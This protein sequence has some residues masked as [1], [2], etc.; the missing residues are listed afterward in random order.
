MDRP[1]R[2]LLEFGPFRLDPDER[3]LL[4]GGER[5]PLP[6]KSL[7]ILL[8]LAQHGGHLFE[9]DELLKAVWPE[10]V[11]EEA[12]IAVHVAALRRALGD[13]QNGRHY[14]ETERGHGYRFTAK[15]RKVPAGHVEP[16]EGRRAGRRGA[17]TV[18]PPHA[19]RMA[20]HPA[21][22][23]ED[24]AESHPS[25][26]T[27]EPVGGA[28]PLDS[29]FYIERPAD[30]EFTSAVLR[31]DMIVLVKGPRQVGKTSLLARGLQR[32]REAGAKVILVDL[33][34]LNAAQMET[35]ETLFLTFAGMAARKLRLADDPARAWDGRLGPNVNFTDFWETEVLARAEG[36]IVW[37]LDEVDRLFTRPYG[38]EVFGLFRSW[39]NMRALDPASPWRHL[40]LA[41][42][43]ATEA[44]LFIT[45]L[46]QSPFNVGTRLSLD[47]FTRGQVGEL[48]RRYRCPLADDELEK[49]F[50]LVGGHPYLVRRGLHE[51]ANSHL[52]LTELEAR[53]T[54][55][56]GPFGDHLRRI[57]FLLGQDASLREALGG[58]VQGRQGLTH[59][60]FYRLRSAGLVAGDSP[61][62]AAFRCRLYENYF[63]QYLT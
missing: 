48:N 55:E 28:V 32:A 21:G 44:H 20:E 62:A 60:S 39:H 54:D 49:F 41:M 47:D 40:T 17:T 5:V 12:N 53:V 22:G 25:P 27:L 3:L 36:H 51:L 19:G 2:Y 63:N 30:A 29:S 37:G 43:Y 11:V 24:L 31:R 16:A 13:G 33:Q 9:K 50:G 26:L 57:L 52:M 10:A 23:R 34:S 59:D 14:I 61:A 35:I 58:F 46:N 6:A 4:V 56:A 38:N 42:A 45:D 1:T 7:D 18:P 15:V 8:A